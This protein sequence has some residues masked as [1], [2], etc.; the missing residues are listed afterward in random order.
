MPGMSIRIVE[1]KGGNTD[2]K[3][4]FSKRREIR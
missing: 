4:A 2:G 1:E 3:K